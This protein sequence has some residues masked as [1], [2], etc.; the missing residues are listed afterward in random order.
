MLSVESRKARR[1]PRRVSKVRSNRG[2][3]IRGNGAGVQA[4]EE[5]GHQDVQL[6]TPRSTGRL[7]VHL[8]RDVARTDHPLR[9]RTSGETHALGGLILASATASQVGTQCVD[10]GGVVSRRGGRGDGAGVGVGGV[11]GG[12]I[13]GDDV[14][15]VC[16]A[17]SRGGLHATYE[18]LVK[19]EWITV[20]IGLQATP[21]HLL[22][23]SALQRNAIP[24]GLQEEVILARVGFETSQ[25]KSL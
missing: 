1:D 23:E 10:E 5:V 7:D 15:G 16:G 11:G 3:V 4:S 14:C 20:E 22:S 24:V 12:G 8:G 13:G 2:I 18:A 6:G 25:P 17:G 9:D 21:S 19:V